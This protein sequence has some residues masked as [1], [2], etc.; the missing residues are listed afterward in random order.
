MILGYFE[1]KRIDSMQK[2]KNRQRLN[3]FYNLLKKNL[4]SSGFGKP[5]KNNILYN[6]GFSKN[7]LKEIFLLLK[8]IIPFL[9]KLMTLK[10]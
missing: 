10:Y 9:S 8:L 5:N 3:S 4:G 6:Y 7:I 1:F 2:G